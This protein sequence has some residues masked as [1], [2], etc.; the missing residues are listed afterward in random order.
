MCAPQKTNGTKCTADAECGNAHCVEGVCC[1]DACS[2]KCNSCLQANTGQTDGT[3]APV[4]TGVVHGTDCPGNAT[5]PAG[6]TTFTGAPTCDGAGACK[7]GPTTACGSYLCNTTTTS[8]A[9]TCSANTQCSTGYC[10][11]PACKAKVAA[12]QL[13]SSNVQCQSGTCSGRC[14]ASGTPCTCTQPSTGNVIK[15]PGFDTNL[16]SWTVDPGAA[17]ITWQP[18][19]QLDGNGSYSDADAC[20]YSGSAYIAE[21]DSADSQL[22]WQCVP[23]VAHTMYNFGVR[24]ATLSGA[25]AFCDVD[26]YQGPNCTG[27]TTNVADFQWLNVAWS[28]GQFPTTFDSSFYISAKVSC[29]VQMGGQFFVDEIYLTP[30]PGMY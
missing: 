1:G 28:S 5:C 23:I 22:I 19:T 21:P 2:A 7:A 27:N 16:S 10:V 17:S 30:A 13:C 25:Y 20:P 6:G 24:I 3:C 29:H 9:N 14:C 12:G 18:G 11:A 4:R 15:N 8:C 26:A